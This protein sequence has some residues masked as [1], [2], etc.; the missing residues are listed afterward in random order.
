M[1]WQKAHRLVLLVYSATKSFPKEEVFGLTSQ[2]RRCAVSVPANIVE[3]YGRKSDKEKLNFFNIAKGSLTELEYYIE[4]TL[5]LG[6][7]N[8]KGF[9]DL[10]QLRSDVGRLLNGFSKSYQ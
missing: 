3:G 10:V 1:V 6:Y 9:S 8:E 2:M 7:I 5:E 4:L